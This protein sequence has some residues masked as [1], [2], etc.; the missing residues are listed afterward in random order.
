LS[1]SVVRLSAQELLKVSGALA[2]ACGVWVDVELL[3]R[4]GERVSEPSFEG[5]PLADHL[6]L[7]RSAYLL[8]GAVGGVRVLE[9]PVGVGSSV[10]RVCS[11]I[12]RGLEWRVLVSLPCELLSELSLD[13]AAGVVECFGSLAVSVG[14]PPLLWDNEEST[15]PRCLLGVEGGSLVGVEY[16]GGVVDG[17]RLSSLA[18]S[19]LRSVLGATL[20]NYQR[21]AWPLVVRVK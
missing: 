11:V 10:V 17:R 3:E 4:W 9:G 21:E 19:R 5:L 16:G 15:R 12:E 7:Y 8:G 6:A 20:P 1:V 2:R 13:Q 14:V 18:A